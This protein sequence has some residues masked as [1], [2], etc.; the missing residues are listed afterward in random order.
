MNISSS[1]SSKEA[2]KTF[3]S[4][5]LIYVSWDM[6]TSL[7]R[8]SILEQSAFYYQVLSLSLSKQCK[9][10]KLHKEV[11]SGAL[12]MILSSALAQINIQMFLYIH[13]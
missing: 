4:A 6:G 8:Q 7:I 2:V 13:Q 12:A 5:C 10:V 11:E 9:Y 1:P 3:R